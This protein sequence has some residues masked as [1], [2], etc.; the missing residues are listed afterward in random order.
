MTLA[1]YILKEMDR[2][3]EFA[4]LWLADHSSGKDEP[5]TEKV[6]PKGYAPK[7]TGK[8]YKVFKVR[9]GKLYPPMVANAG[10]EDTPIG[11]WLD[12]EEGEFAGLSKT[13]RP[14][15]KSTGGET[16]SYRPGWHLGDV[17]RAP[18]FD[19]TNKQTG[20]KEFPKDF[21]WAECDYAMDIDYQPESD[22]QGYMRTKVDDKGNVVTYRSDKY[23]H[24]LA[25]LPKLPKDGYYKYR[26]NPR[27]DTVPWVITGQMKVNRL[28]SDDEVNDILKSKGIEPIHRQGGDKTL[29]E[30]GLNEGFNERP[31]KSK[32]IPTVGAY[33]GQKGRNLSKCIHYREDKEIASSNTYTEGIQFEPDDREKG[34]IIIFSTEVNAKEL[35][36]NAVANWIK[37]KLSSLSNRINRFRKIDRIGKKHDLVGW[38]VGKYLSGR[39]TA[40][41]GKAFGED[42]LSLEIIGV[43]SDTLF[44][45]AEDVCKEFNQEAVLVKDYSTGRILFIDAE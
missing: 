19:R 30:L 23:Q 14:Q 3:E 45:I 18:Q 25:G 40:K 6:S 8:A 11:V 43:D 22:E 10:G 37:Q 27:P 21:V 16:L 12:A 35:S 9:N 33:S 44:K 31:L 20:E 15:V 32:E 41:N 1:D 39:Y 29:K 42:S 28:L 17:P 36:T 4:K 26:T 13:G 5:M 24:S 34:G 38:T 7:K 2:D